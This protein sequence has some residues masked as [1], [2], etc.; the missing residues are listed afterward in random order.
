MSD[1][2]K[3]VTPIPRAHNPI[4]ADLSRADD[5]VLLSLNAW[6]DVSLESR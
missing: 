5:R 2:M 4:A 1:P 3:L 6:V